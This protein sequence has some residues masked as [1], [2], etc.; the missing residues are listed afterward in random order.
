M[1]NA[2]L[3]T[4][5]GAGYML[6]RWHK[7]RWALALAG[8]AAGKRWMLRPGNSIGRV[9]ESTPEVG[10]AANELRG[11]LTDVG[12]KAAVAAASGQMATLTSRLQQRTQSLKGAA[13]VAKGS[14]EDSDI[15]EEPEGQEEDEP[16]P[17]EQSPRRTSRGADGGSRGAHKPTSRNSTRG[18]SARKSVASKGS[19]RV[20]SRTST[21]DEQG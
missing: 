20:R 12:K 8:A 3:A 5:V 7:A 2:K 11:T 19:S 16:E 18:A 10:A 21:H 14:Q 4:A 9:L 6:G 1:K 15:D 13:K 17:E